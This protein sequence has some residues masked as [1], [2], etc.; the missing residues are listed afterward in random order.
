MKKT[1]GVQFKKNDVLCTENERVTILSKK[2]KNNYI[3][4]LQILT[5]QLKFALALQA[6][7]AQLVRASDC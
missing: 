1:N 2:N 3:K 7:L 6:S 4:I 5:I